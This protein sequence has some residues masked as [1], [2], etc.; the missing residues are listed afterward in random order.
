MLKLVILAIAVL[1][2]PEATIQQN[3][4]SMNSVGTDEHSRF[5][6]AIATAIRNVKAITDPAESAL[7]TLKQNAYS[8]N[9]QLAKTFKKISQD[10]GEKI[11]EAQEVKSETEAERENYLSAASTL[12]A[13]AEEEQEGAVEDFEDQSNSFISEM[14]E[15]AQQVEHELESHTEETAESTEEVLEAALGGISE[16]SDSLKENG[17]EFEGKVSDVLS[18][19]KDL[20]GEIKGVTKVLDGVEKMYTSAVTKAQQAANNFQQQLAADAQTAQD[21]GQKGTDKTSGVIAKEMAGLQKEVTGEQKR[22]ASDIAAKQKEFKAQGAALVDE[23]TNTRIT[24]NKAALNYFSAQDKAQLDVDSQVQKL[25]EKGAEEAHQASRQSAE[26]MGKVNEEKDNLARMIQDK[27]EKFQGNVDREAMTMRS[28]ITGM[29]DEENAK[30]MD[31]VERIKNYVNT[32]LSDSRTSIMEGGEQVLGTTSKLDDEIADVLRMTYK[33]S[34]QMNSNT[35]VYTQLGEEDKATQA[36]VTAKMND[37]LSRVQTS[38]MDLDESVTQQIDQTDQSISEDADKEK[39]VALEQLTAVKDSILQKIGAAGEAFTVGEQKTKRRIES[40]QQEI[41]AKL[42]ALASA[43]GDLEKESGNMAVA[44]PE[45]QKAIEQSYGGVRGDLDKMFTDLDKS[46]GQVAEYIEGEQQRGNAAAVKDLEMAQNE[47]KER[48]STASTDLSGIMKQLRESLGEFE[49]KSNEEFGDTSAK[50]NGLNGKIEKLMATVAKALEKQ[51]GN[52]KELSD[53]TADSLRKM[54]NGEK[55]AISGIRSEME[56][57]REKT[58]SIIGKQQEKF[59]SDLKMRTMQSADALDKVRQSATAAFQM[60][61]DK[62]KQFLQSTGQREEELAQKANS[63]GLEVETMVSNVDK[64]IDADKMRMSQYAKNEDMQIAAGRSKME[65]M[66][67]GVTGQYKQLDSLVFAQAGNF[68]KEQKQAMHELSKQS[69]E[70]TSAE[71][72]RQ[73][74]AQAQMGQAE[75]QFMAEADR[76]LHAMEDA[77]KSVGAATQRMQSERDSLTSEMI[78]GVQQ[79][80]TAVD[81]GESKVQNAISGEEKKVL[82]GQNEGLGSME[83]LLV[84]MQGM[85]GAADEDVSKMAKNAKAELEYM[86][87]KNEFLS[88]ET[89]KKIEQLEDMP[90]LAGQFEDDVKPVKKQLD[91]EASRLGQE[92]NDTEAALAKDANTL[93]GVRKRRMDKAIR[94]HNEATD[95]KAHYVGEMSDAVDKLSTYQKSSGDEYKA[96][97]GQLKKFDQQ[98]TMISGFESNHDTELIDG[99]KRKTIKLQNSNDKLLEWQRN[100]KYRTL[101]FNTEVERRLRQLEGQMEDEEGQIANERLNEDMALNKNMRRGSKNIDDQM[102]KL[103]S[104]QSAGMGSMVDNVRKGMGKL[105]NEEAGFEAAEQSEMNDAE[106]QVNRMNTD[107]ET[108]MEDLRNG[109][110]TVQGKVGNFRKTL[111]EKAQEVNNKLFLQKKELEDTD[112]ANKELELKKKLAMLSQPHGSLLETDADEQTKHDEEKAAL[113]E[114]N[115]KM[116][117]ENARLEHLDDGLDAKVAKLQ[118]ALQSLQKKK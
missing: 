81:T 70:E 86:K 1:G 89:A 47:L 56:K 63:V 4:Q 75:G 25:V 48:F 33:I 3:T 77:D 12:E 94:L 55:A 90:D 116:E 113:L 58:N 59:S 53:F 66:K 83:G 44:I 5:S 100:F 78:N 9:N 112:S 72:E 96:L 79:A 98:L 104:M 97:G 28:Q 49:A 46:K 115:A 32:A 118:T 30:L 107:T 69:T 102:S 95:M 54:H 67:K 61:E 65:E 50:A 35:E 39:S 64:S 8:Q 57:A 29:T 111:S 17:K 21:E 105:M 36:D 22:M 23:L 52:A 103:S 42:A 51:S 10:I 73:G 7:S 45:E 15:G 117:K 71:R 24:Q 27:Y 6:Q 37:L 84:G 87:H 109:A 41:S 108:A 99:L 74:M 13:R 19:Q 16:E 82:E 43:V 11:Q 101:A 91:Q 106:R 14:D 92:F 18:S 38:V 2:D 34:K 40:S 114:F 31:M 80:K 68:A 26:A 60:A 88:E 93:E 85:Q 110:N 76:S 20:R 62:R